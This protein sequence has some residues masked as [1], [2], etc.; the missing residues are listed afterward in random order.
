MYFWKYGV[1]SDNNA[2]LVTLQ[3]VDYDAV[4]SLNCKL[5]A[6]YFR[7]LQM[8]KKQHTFSRVNTNWALYPP[9]EQYLLQGFRIRL[10]Q[11]IEGPNTCK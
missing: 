2:T 7:V 1:Q 4:I 10:Y 9:Q 11:V 8:L 6:L 5:I 3:A